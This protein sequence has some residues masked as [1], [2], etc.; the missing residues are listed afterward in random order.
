MFVAKSS[1]LYIYFKMI[2]CIYITRRSY[3]RSY[4]YILQDDHM[5]V[6][7]K[8][9]IWSDDETYVLCVGCS[10]TKIMHVSMK[11]LFVCWESLR[12]KIKILCKTNQNFI[13]QSDFCCIACS[14]HIITKL[15]LLRTLNRSFKGGGVILNLMDLGN[16]LNFKEKFMLY[17]WWF[18]GD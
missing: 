4:V 11:R 7:Y 1:F 17:Q 15:S 2:I 3:V 9:I 5:Y 6:Y 10:S 18:W 14:N 12:P 16:F 8:M 13:K